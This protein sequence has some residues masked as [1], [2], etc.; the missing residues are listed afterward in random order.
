MTSQTH[1]E[2][3]FPA[4]IA[5]CLAAMYLLSLEGCPAAD[6]LDKTA[7]LWVRLLWDDRRVQWHEQ[8]DDAR[9]RAAFASMGA[10]CKRWPTPAVFW[11]HLPKREA[12][13]GKMLGAGYGRE[14]QAEALA[15]MQGWL[16]SLGRD[17]NGDIIPGHPNA[18]VTP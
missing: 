5:K 1:P 15:H 18:P 8:A 17:R 10:A 4:L 12:P 11:E 2:P 13:R 7:Q 3:W 16:E 6:A 9:I 14:R